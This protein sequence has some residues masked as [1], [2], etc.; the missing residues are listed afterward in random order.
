MLVVTVKR[1]G[2]VVDKTTAEATS[3]W[4]VLPT[5]AGRPLGQG[6]AWTGENLTGLLAEMRTS[7]GH[8]VARL[9][10]RE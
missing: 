5:V 1:I 2:Y 7:L 10:V 8:A 4:A 3:R 6:F 9:V